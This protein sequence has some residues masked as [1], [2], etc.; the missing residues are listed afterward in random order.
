[1]GQK[2]LFQFFLFLEQSIIIL[3]VE[4]KC[5]FVWLDLTY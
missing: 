5:E 1:M 4:R 3:L 2:N